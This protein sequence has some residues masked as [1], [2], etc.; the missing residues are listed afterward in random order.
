MTFAGALRHDGINAPRVI[1]G[2]INSESFRTHVEQVSSTNCGPTT[3]SR[4]TTSAATRHP[5]RKAAECTREVVWRRNGSLLDQFTPQECENCIRNSG[6]GSVQGHRAPDAWLFSGSPSQT[7]SSNIAPG[8][9][10]EPHYDDAAGILARDTNGDEAA[11][12]FL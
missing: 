9:A 1:D 7:E 8:S 10:G 2:P 11:D 3:S 4:W 5:L 6:Y 12:F